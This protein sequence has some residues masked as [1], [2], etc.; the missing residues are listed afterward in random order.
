MANRMGP[1]GAATA[2]AA[3]T[4]V[5]LTLALAEPFGAAGTTA[6]LALGQLVGAAVGSG[7]ARRQRLEGY[8]GVRGLWLPTVAVVLVLAVTVPGTT[9]SGPARAGLL[10]A[11]LVVAGGVER[12]LLRTGIRWV[13]QRGR[14]ARD[15]S[16]T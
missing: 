14:R 11:F 8:L 5:V 13:V 2:A 10:L 9:P 15:T 16:A 3:I 12:T 7:L 4:T 6:A 1:I